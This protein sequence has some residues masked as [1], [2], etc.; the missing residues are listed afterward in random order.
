[1][2]EPFSILALDLHNTLYDEALE[3]G[4]SVDEA[5]S[6]WTELAGDKGVTLDRQTLYR[7]LS[8]GHRKY[9]SDWDTGAWAEMPSLTALKLSADDFA[10]AV[11]QAESRRKEKSKSLAVPS[12][13]PGILETLRELKSRRVRIF[14]VTEAAADAGM[15]MLDWLGLGGIVDGFYSYPS[16][17]SPLSIPGMYHASFP[18]R[19]NGGHFKKPHPY[20]LAAVIRDELLRRE[21]IA[22]DITLD[23][24]FEVAHNDA[25]I[26]PELPRDSLTQSDL[27]ARL[28]VRHTPHRREIMELVNGMLYIGDSKFKDGC[29]AHNA[30]VAFGWAA[31]GK[32]IKPENQTL[33]AKSLEIMYAVTGWDPEVLKLTQDAGKSPVIAAL[34]PEYTVKDS[35]SEILPLFVM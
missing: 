10:K 1:M 21:R 30:G 27:A 19:A 31:Y 18:L 20:L 13:Y 23:E 9:G 22:P 2:P 6:Y 24:L 26:L 33:H 16:R 11:A 35:L 32:K 28:I 8:L 12:L 29:L 25:R 7:E 5:I 4:L 15:E 34:Q 3:Y 17:R 14:V